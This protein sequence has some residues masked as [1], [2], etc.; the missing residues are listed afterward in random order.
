MAISSHPSIA[1]IVPMHNRAHCVLATLQSILAQTLRP[2]QLIVVDNASTDASK[3]VVERWMTH[4]KPRC[5]LLLLSEPTP[6]AAAARNRGLPS[7][8]AEWVTFFDSD[9]WMSPDFLEKMLYSA[10]QQG[11]EWVIARTQM[12]FGAAPTQQPLQSSENHRTDCPQNHTLV[13][14]WSTAHPT[15]A[16]QILS[17]CISTQSFVARTTLVRRIGGWNVQLPL[18]DDYEIALRLLLAS[19]QPAWCSAVFHRIFQHPDSITGTD[20]SSRAAQITQALVSIAQTLHTS[21][22]FSSVAQRRQ[23]YAALHL[24]THIVAGQLMREKASQAAS[25]LLQTMDDLLPLPSLWMRISSCFLRHYVQYG[26][27]GAWRIART[28]TRLP[29]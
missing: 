10:E 3:S 23:A 27:R 17:A 20:Y 13:T 5:E 4:Q 1:V 26:G 11:R 28:L 15:L 18:W 12:V 16:D 21:S 8:T 24:R 14:R 6:G 25:T 22:D 19:P 2:A 29:F 7:V 9:D